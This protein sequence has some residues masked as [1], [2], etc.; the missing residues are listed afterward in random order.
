MVTVKLKAL[1]L[2][3]NVSIEFSGHSDVVLNITVHNYF[4]GLALN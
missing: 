3:Q 1:M 2:R 4:M